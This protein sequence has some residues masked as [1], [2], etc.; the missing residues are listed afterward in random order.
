MPRPPTPATD[1]SSL[2]SAFFDQ[3]AAI[4]RG[5]IAAPPPPV[6]RLA[7]FA[8]RQHGPLSVLAGLALGALLVAGALWAA[9]G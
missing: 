9:G 5:T 1:F 4:E 7:R 2:E 6:G 8:K 3:G